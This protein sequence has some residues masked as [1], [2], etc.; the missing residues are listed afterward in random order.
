MTESTAGDI[1]IGTTIVIV[2]VAALFFLSTCAREVSDISSK[3]S[4]ELVCAEQH[5]TNQNDFCRNYKK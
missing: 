1:T 4:P 3:R 2:S 5:V